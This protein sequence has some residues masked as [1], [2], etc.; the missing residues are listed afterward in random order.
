MAGVGRLFWAIAVTAVVCVPIGVSLWA[1]LDCVRHPQ[2][3]WALSGRRQLVWL[4]AI[5][6]GFVSV[7]GG[8]LVS[9]WYLLKVRPVVAAAERGP[10]SEPEDR[11][12]S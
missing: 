7:V 9:G 1:L 8:L 11:S 3:A 10:L 2:W 6:F 12:R 5:L 4:I